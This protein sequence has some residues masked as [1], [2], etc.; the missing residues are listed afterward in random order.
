MR[1]PSPSMPVV[2]NGKLAGEFSNYLNALAAA[3]SSLEVA[4]RGRAEAADVQ[5]LSADFRQQL[6]GEARARE[7]GLAAAA[8]SRSAAVE[9]LLFR[10]EAIEGQG[11]GSAPWAAAVDPSGTAPPVR[12]G[13][14]DAGPFTVLHGDGAWKPATGGVQTLTDGVSIAWDVD[15]G[16]TGVVTLGGN[17]QLATPTGGADGGWYLLRAVQ[18]ATGSRTLD[19]HAGI[20]RGGLD[21]PALSAAPGAVDLLLLTRIDAAWRYAG[22]VAGA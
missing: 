22:I 17:R 12:L 7:A 6:A 2:R 10:V 14:G 20:A 13:T 16:A 9:G 1:G 11:P 5:R 18:D 15:A 3:L 19:L 21:P 8:E 4:L